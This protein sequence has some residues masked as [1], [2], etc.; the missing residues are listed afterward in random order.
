MQYSGTLPK[1]YCV[2]VAVCAASYSFDRLFSYLS[3]QPIAPGCRVIVPFGKGNAKRV[4]IVLTCQEQEQ[5]ESQLK[6][7]LSVV[8]QA[9]LLSREMLDLVFWLK[10]MTFC[11]YFDAVRT[12]LPAG[13]QVQLVEEITLATAPPDVP[14]TPAEEH[15]LFFLRSAK[16]KREFRQILSDS[17]EKGKTV[18]RA[19]IAKGFLH[20]KDVVKEKNHGQTGIR[21][22]RLVERMDEMPLALTKSQ[23]KLAAILREAGPMSEK[24]ACYLSGVTAAVSKKLVQ[25]GAAESYVVKPPLHH[26]GSGKPEKDPKE[27]CLSPEQQQVYDRVAAALSEGMHCFLLHGVTGSGKTSVFIRLIDTVVSMGK[28]VILLVPEIS[29]TPQIVQQFC[30]LFGDIVAVIHSELSLG[31][32]SDAWRKIASGSVKIIIGTRSAV[33]AP[34]QNLGLI[35]VDEEG[36]RTYKSDSAPRYHAIA[37]AKKRCQTHGCP[38]LLAS[39]TPSVE[40]YYY[41]KRGIYTLLEMKQRYNQSPLP[42]VE[43][44]DM[45]EERTAG[46]DGMFSETLAL[47]L[48]DNWKAGKQSLLLLNRR[49]YHT[50]ISCASCNQPVYCPNCSIPMTYHKVNDSLMCHYCGH[51]QDLVETCPSCGSPHLMRMG[52]GTQRIQQELERELPGVRVM[53]MDADTTGTKSAYFDMLTSFRNHGADI[54]LGT[55]MVTKGHDFPDVTLVGV[56][57]ADMSLYV[58]D[59]RA[60]ERTFSLLTQVIGR[61]GRADKP[62]LAVI[63]TMNPDNDVLKLACAQ[64]YETF[65]AREV[66]LRRNLAFPPFCDIALLTLTST[67]EK[68]LQKACLRLTEEIRRLTANGYTDVPMQM[69]GPF[70]APVYRVDNV[71]RMRTVIKCRLTRRARALFTELLRAFSAL[72]QRPVLSVDFNPSSI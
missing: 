64:D 6:N 69:F 40:S 37:V 58:D 71:Y 44:V 27:I 62:G 17:D 14:L 4:G 12:I 11:T 15:L 41:A 26:Y 55:Q 3:L 28:Q 9:P 36:E 33:F 61:A 5:T 57:L 34:V 46:N 16:T 22:L 56:L 63:Q 53:R 25:I 47:A 48:Q 13:M 2:G 72:R 66:R 23:E 42:T 1:K 43:V 35:V 50:I 39:A 49:G 45:Q 19:L 21:M 60:A 38:L 29:L 51:T 24:E 8:D 30:D 65:Y 31:Q 52:F 68:E 20:Q 67:D 70:E 54:L 32:R 59:Y 7:V 18:I 10:E